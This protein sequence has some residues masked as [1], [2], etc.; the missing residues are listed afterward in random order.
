MKR[1]EFIQK[2]SK[3]GLG[4]GALSLIRPTNVEGGVSDNS[5]LNKIVGNTDISN[6][7]NTLTEAVGNEAL[8]TKSKTLSGAINETKQ[9][10]GTQC[11]FSLNGT[12]LTITSK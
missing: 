10:L 5:S 12:T 2:L 3:V 1:K 9:G 7:A 4:I 6:V 8:Q 11:T